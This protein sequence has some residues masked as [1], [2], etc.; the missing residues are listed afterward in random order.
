MV[1][2]VGSK[3]K[4]E[5]ALHDGNLNVEELDWINTLDKYFDHED[6]KE[7][8]K[9]KYSMTRLRGHATLWWDELQADQRKER[10][11]EY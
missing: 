3:P 8:Q 1:T 9:V 10:D 11:N 7:D 2:K 5:V 6:V 4:I